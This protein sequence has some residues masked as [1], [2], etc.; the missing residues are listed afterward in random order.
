MTGWNIATTRPG[1]AASSSS[2]RATDDTVDAQHVTSPSRTRSSD[3]RRSTPIGLSGSGRYRKRQILR[4]PGK[5]LCGQT[6]QN[7]DVSQLQTM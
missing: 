6:T 4:A 2:Q 1:L 5:P 3:G 7:D